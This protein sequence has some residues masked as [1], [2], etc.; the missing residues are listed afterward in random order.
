MSDRPRLSAKERLFVVVASIAV[1][2]ALVVA[3][4]ISFVTSMTLAMILGLAYF[5]FWSRYP[6]VNE[7]RGGGTRVRIG[8]RK[9]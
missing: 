9:E 1:L 2:T 3:Q 7:K 8:K 4:S 6:S 5:I